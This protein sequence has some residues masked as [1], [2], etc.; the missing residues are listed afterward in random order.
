MGLVFLGYDNCVEVVL[1]RALSALPNSGLYTLERRIFLV[2]TQ[3]L[4][5]AKVSQM[6]SAVFFLVVCPQF[7][8][9]FLLKKLNVTIELQNVRNIVVRS[10]LSPRRLLDSWRK[11]G[12][13][14]P[15]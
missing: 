1:S 14:S 6:Y 3:V 9:V 13:K 11:G 12:E 15:A 5:N 7:F 4:Y 2:G 8:Y 10:N